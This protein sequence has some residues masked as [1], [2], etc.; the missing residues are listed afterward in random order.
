MCGFN[1]CRGRMKIY[2]KKSIIND[3]VMALLAFLSIFLLFYEVLANTTIEGRRYIRY[4]DLT[5]AFIFLVD[6]IFHLMR[7]KD[8]ATFLKYRWWE[9]LAA[10]P[11][12][13]ETTE[14]LRALKMARILPL[15]EGLRFVR[16]AVRIKLLLEYSRKLTK[17]AY[18]IYIATILCSVILSGAFGFH[19]FE[20]GKNPHV[21]NFFDSIWWA[22]VTM[23]TIG[24]GD[25]YPVTTGGR[26][27]AI[28]LMF[29]GVGALGAFIGAMN[30]YF[31]NKNRQII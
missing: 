13:T 19:Y 20:A 4:V 12:T 16:L 8:K 25:I 27:V 30:A 9:I 22:I 24:Y 18:M 28:I 3:A 29:V 14:A 10:I 2:S 11:I 21:N 5:I 1:S 15:I 23:A 31:F 26:I 6:F 7:A 17:H